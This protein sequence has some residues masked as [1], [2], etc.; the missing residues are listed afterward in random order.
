MDGDGHHD[1]ML[2]EDDFDGDGYE[3]D[4]AA[5][6]DT[7]GLWF[8]SPEELWHGSISLRINGNDL[9]RPSSAGWCCLKKIT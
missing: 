8:N 9:W 2:M 5:E 4:D 1:E 7:E 3:D 6:M